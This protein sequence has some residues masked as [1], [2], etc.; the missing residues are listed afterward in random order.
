MVI[1]IFCSIAPAVFINGLSILFYLNYS[2]GYFAEIDLAI[3]DTV[4][5]GNKFCLLSFSLQ[6]LSADQRECKKEQVEMK[7]NLLI[8]ADNYF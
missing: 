4:N 2:A 8:M 5:F 6:T 1:V 3:N 7:N